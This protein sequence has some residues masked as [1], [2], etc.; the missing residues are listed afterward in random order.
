M[1]AEPMVNVQKLESMAPEFQ[2]LTDTMRR[3]VQPSSILVDKDGH[4]SPTKASSRPA[5]DN[6]ARETSAEPTTKSHPRSQSREKSSSSKRSSSGSGYH[7]RSSSSHEKSSSS[8]HHRSSQQST[9]S[10]KHHESGSSSSKSRDQ[11]VKV[12]VSVAQVPT[13]APELPRAPTQA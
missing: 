1:G 7:E 5:S 2:T 6:S 3:G 4:P 13:P 10:T 8:H 11:Q 9:S 12:P